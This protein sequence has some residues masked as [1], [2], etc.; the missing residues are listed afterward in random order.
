MLNPDKIEAITR[1]IQ[2]ILPENVKEIGQDFDR[3]I[4]AILQAQLGRLDV[5][6]RE[7]FDVQARVLG[8]TRE[9]LEQLEAQ[10]EKLEKQLSDE[11]N[12]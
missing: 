6:T 12:L 7:E 9:K 2:S 8:K 5:V 3:K 1:Q 10:V 4:K 11:G